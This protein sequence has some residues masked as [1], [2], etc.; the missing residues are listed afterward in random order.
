MMT[1][2]FIIIVIIIIMMMI[3]IISAFLVVLSFV[4]MVRRRAQTGMDD[5]HHC[6]C[7]R[8]GRIDRT[9]VKENSREG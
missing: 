6:E 4:L 7:V 9:I 5:G 2:I 3:I 8:N 1:M